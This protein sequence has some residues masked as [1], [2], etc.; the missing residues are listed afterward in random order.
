MYLGASA[1]YIV[2]CDAPTNFLINMRLQDDWPTAAKHA[3][4]MYLYANAG[5]ASTYSPLFD[6]EPHLFNVGWSCKTNQKG[7]F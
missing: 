7:A 6:V 4:H 2:C 5:T 3:R 1:A